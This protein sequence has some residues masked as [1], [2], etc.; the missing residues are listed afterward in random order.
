MKKYASALLVAAAMQISA[1]PL[2]EAQSLSEKV[3]IAKVQTQKL[4]INV[5]DVKQLQSLPGIGLKKAQA[6][7][8][9]RDTHGKFTSINDLAKVKGIGS[10][11]IAKFSSKAVVN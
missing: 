11:M 5:A 8:E 10:K 9:Y 3:E 4:N 6:I 7:I 1:L 2:A